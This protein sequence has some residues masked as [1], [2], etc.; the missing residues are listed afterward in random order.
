MSSSKE[1]K[2]NYF[3]K[4]IK[5]LFDLFGYK[6]S[7]KNNFLDRYND[8]IVECDEKNTQLI[9]RFQKISLT[10]SLNLWSMIQSIQHIKNNEINGD[11]VECG[12]FRGGALALICFYAQQLKIE[13]NIYGYDTFEDGFLENTIGAFDTTIKGRENKFT[14]NPKNFY[15]S[16]NQVEE[17][18]KS[19]SVSGNYLPK[20]IKGDVMKTLLEEK[21]LPKSISFLRLDTDLYKTTKMQLEILYP[22]LSTG[23]V[24]HID[25]YGY[26]PGVRKATDEFFVNKKVWLHRIDLTCRYLVKY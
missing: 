13:K 24:L 23:G 4:K 14:G 26:C 11:L 22:R 17:T 25:D 2:E 19:F 1:I 5:S 10:T 20:L 8:F 18:I 12:V 7:R 16:I 15:P 6:I 21:N 9:K 3:K